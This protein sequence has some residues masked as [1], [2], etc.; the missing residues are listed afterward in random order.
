MDEYL[1]KSSLFKD[2]TKMSTPGTIAT[3]LLLVRVLITF[4]DKPDHV[5]HPGRARLVR[6]VEVLFY[7][8]I[9]IGVLNWLCSKGETWCRVSWGLVIVQ[10]AMILVTALLVLATIRFLGDLAQ[11]Q[12]MYEE[13]TIQ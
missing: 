12:K 7:G 13:V 8:I 3:I 4:L 1:Q 5:T 9:Y 6:T 2:I 10:I 11:K